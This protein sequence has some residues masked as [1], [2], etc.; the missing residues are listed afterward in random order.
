MKAIKLKGT[1]VARADKHNMTIVVR[2]DRVNGGFN[3]I[4]VNVKTG[5]RV[6]RSERAETKQGVSRAVAEE[7]RLLN[8]FLGQEGGIGEASRNRNFC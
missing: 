7:A 3:V 8:K 1:E 2:P 6:W 4:A 5:E